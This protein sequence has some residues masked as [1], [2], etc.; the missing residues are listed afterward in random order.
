M[1]RSSINRLLNDA[2]ND[3][4]SSSPTQ[5]EPGLKYGARQ[6]AGALQQQWISDPTTRCSVNPCILT[7]N[8]LPRTLWDLTRS[9][10]GLPREHLVEGVMKPLST[11]LN[12]E[13]VENYLFEMFQLEQ[14]EF[15]KHGQGR[16]FC[17]WIGRIGPGVIFIEDIVRVPNFGGPQISELTQAVYTDSFRIDSLKYVFVMDIANKITRDLIQTQIYS[18]QN[19][20]SWPDSTLRIWEYGT[21]E[22]QALLGTPLGKSVA[23]LLLGAFA[24]GTRRIARIASWEVHGC[25]QLRFDI[26]PVV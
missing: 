2:P 9:H 21:P 12:N 24:R 11:V 8:D 17:H 6:E 15:E 16:I 25:A 3:P 5:A 13:D 19:G 14:N 10:D 1:A 4:A 22:Y 26:E 23:A 7:L 20:L 18:Q